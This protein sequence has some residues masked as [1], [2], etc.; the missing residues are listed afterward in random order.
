MI[1]ITFVHQK[2]QLGLGHALLTTKKIIGNEPFLLLLPDDIFE[3]GELVLNK[4]MEIHERYQT[5]VI[6]VKQVE[7]IEVSRY[8][9][10]KPDYISERIY[11][12]ADLVEKPAPAEAHSDLAMMG[13]CVLNPEIFQVLENTPPGR[14]GEYQLIDGLKQLTRQKPIYAYEFEGERYD[15]STPLGWLQTNIALGLKD[16]TIGADLRGYIIR[17]LQTTRLLNKTIT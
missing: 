13:R 12:V 8:G 3:Q 5:S 7:E 10:I 9:I 16:P 15:I 4:M 1:D 17:L 2:E 11:R 6:A 14:N